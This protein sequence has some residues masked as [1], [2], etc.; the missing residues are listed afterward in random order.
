MIDNNN[1]KKEK[2]KNKISE[3]GL[4]ININGVS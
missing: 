4:Y 1:N 2:K 3:K